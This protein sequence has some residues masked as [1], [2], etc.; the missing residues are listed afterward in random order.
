MSRR[1]Q[2]TSEILDWVEIYSNHRYLSKPEEIILE[3]LKNRLPSM[4]MLD[5]GVGGGRTTHYFA[6]L[7]KEYVG[8][9]SDENMIRSCRKKF[10]FPPS[11]VSF[12]TCDVRSMGIFENGYFDFI[13]FSFNGLDYL[14]HE[15]RRK[16]LREIRRV[17]KRGE[18]FLFSAHNLNSIDEQ[19]RVEIS[20]NPLNLSKSIWKYLLLRIRN[21]NLKKLKTREYAVINDGM[22][23]KKLKW[24]ILSLWKGLGHFYYVT[25]EAQLRQLEDIGFKNIEVYALNGEEIAGKARMKTA[26]DHWLHYL[27]EI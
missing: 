25:P 22:Y 7:A 16:S 12:V 11:K 13:L 3:K 9:D 5:I 21:E 1:H 6:E 27:C 20:K 17:G 14:R 4:R 2:N 8:I 10:S 15:D 26:T 19:F 18:Y 24:L 23:H